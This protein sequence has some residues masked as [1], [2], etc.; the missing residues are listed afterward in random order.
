MPLQGSLVTTKLDKQ[1]LSDDEYVD[2][3]LTQRPC[4][5]ME[6][7]G[8]SRKEARSLSLDA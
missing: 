4:P 5:N 2:P 7:L 8:M 3:A 1:D 6:S